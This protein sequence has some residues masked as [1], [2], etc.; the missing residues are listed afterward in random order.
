M[1][2]KSAIDLTDTFRFDKIIECVMEI[3]KLENN[4]KLF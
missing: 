3:K 1:K 4:I 2:P